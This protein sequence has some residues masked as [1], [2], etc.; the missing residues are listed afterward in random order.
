M[1]GSGKTLVA[2]GTLQ[3]FVNNDYA[4]LSSKDIPI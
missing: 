1:I 4:G 2:M 3:S